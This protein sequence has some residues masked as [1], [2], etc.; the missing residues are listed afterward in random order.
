MERWWPQGIQSPW[1][2]LWEFQPAIP[3]LEHGTIFSSG[4]DYFYK[5]YNVY[6]EVFHS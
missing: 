6:N 5:V 1:E 3:S 2:T 4:P